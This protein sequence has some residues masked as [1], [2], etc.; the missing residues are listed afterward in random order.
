MDSN[1]LRTGIITRTTSRMSYKYNHWR[2]PNYES[3]PIYNNCEDHRTKWAE[4]IMQDTILNKIQQ[5][6]QG[7]PNPIKTT[8]TGNPRF[9]I[10]QIYQQQFKNDM[11]RTI[12]AKSSVQLKWNHSSYQ[13]QPRL[14]QMRSLI[15][16]ILWTDHELSLK[17]APCLI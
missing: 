9:T 3:R 10:W 15:P 6:N 11:Q 2:Q 12:M 1:E 13:I 17:M 5:A 4:R 16:T 14:I 8:N 7:V